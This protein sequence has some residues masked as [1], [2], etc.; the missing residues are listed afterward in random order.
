MSKLKV[1]VIGL[2][3]VTEE[4]IANY[5]K[6][7]KEKTNEEI[8]TLTIYDAGNGEVTL[9]YTTKPPKFERIRRI[10]GYLVGTTE[11]FNNAKQAEEKDRVK[12]KI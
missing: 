1:K 11:R 12:H 6:F 8:L 10:T 7:L 3:D 5:V 4:E 2:S 9:E